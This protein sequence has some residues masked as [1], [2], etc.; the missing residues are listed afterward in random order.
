MHVTGAVN[1]LH[2]GAGTTPPGSS[3][4]RTLLGP[5][6]KDKR[7]W[8]VSRTSASRYDGPATRFPGSSSPA[9]GP[10][11]A[12]GP[13][14][15]GRT[16]SPLH[17][18]SGRWLPYQDDMAFHVSALGPGPLAQ[19]EM[20]ASW[21]A[22][23]PWCHG[24]ARRGRSDVVRAARLLYGYVVEAV[25]AIPGDGYGRIVAIETL[26]SLLGAGWWRVTAIL[27]TQ[28]VRDALPRDDPPDDLFETIRNPHEGDGIP[29]L[30]KAYRCVR[31]RPGSRASRE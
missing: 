5:R 1:A 20:W 21:L 14:R 2:A 7:I 10:T 26:D 12:T 13:S 29:A 22:V 3:S 25:A 30:G 19:I 17:R 16:G 28:P 6:G 11:E 27:H 24:A 15:R 31:R 18:L 9:S 8:A 23:G 4:T